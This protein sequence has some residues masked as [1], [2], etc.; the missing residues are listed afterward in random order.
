MTYDQI[1]GP[2][3][4]KPIAQSEDREMVPLSS[5]PKREVAPDTIAKSAPSTSS[6]GPGRTPEPHLPRLPTANSQLLSAVQGHETDLFGPN[7]LY[8]EAFNAMNQLLREY[9]SIRGQ[10]RLREA[11]QSMEIFIKQYEVGKEAADIGYEAAMKKAASTLV[12]A[13]GN[14]MTAT[15]SVGQTCALTAN[16]GRAK[17]DFQ[18]DLQAKKDQL[19]E[20][21]DKRGHIAADQPAEL[22]Q[23][24]VLIEKKRKEIA[25]F[26]AGEADYLFRKSS[27]YDQATQASFGAV[28]EALNGVTATIK[29]SQ[30]V[31]VA[32]LEQYK[33]ILD[34]F[35]RL[36]EQMFSA[37]AQHSQSGDLSTIIDQFYNS[38]LNKQASARWSSG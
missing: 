25:D 12:E 33:E 4:H 2:F 34:L 36:F 22:A 6:D 24:D 3:G 37:T 26:E 10:S 21:E 11:L 31:E 18:Q 14:F 8:A 9:L 23:A 5:I 38:I 1:S 27:H 7:A 17:Q 15:V 30:A 13:I 35:K 19:K 20:L 29:A 16:S 28:K 32:S